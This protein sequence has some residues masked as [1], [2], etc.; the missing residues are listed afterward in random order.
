M[1]PVQIVI[2]TQT[3]LDKYL[4]F[5]GSLPLNEELAGVRAQFRREFGQEAGQLAAQWNDL[6]AKLQEAETALI[7][8]QRETDAETEAG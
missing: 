7:A 1:E 4:A 8:L 6:Q 2:V 5:V 3:T